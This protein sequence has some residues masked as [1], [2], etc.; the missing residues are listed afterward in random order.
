M[1]TE[2]FTYYCLICEDYH[3]SDDDPHEEEEE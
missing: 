3:E 2:S 1:L